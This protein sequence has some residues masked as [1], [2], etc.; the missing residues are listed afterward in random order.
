MLDLL[1]KTVR[2]YH[3]CRSDELYVQ[4]LQS[5]TRGELLAVFAVHVT[6]WLSYEVGVREHF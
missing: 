5:T 2:L 1:E 6:I 4:S 3:N